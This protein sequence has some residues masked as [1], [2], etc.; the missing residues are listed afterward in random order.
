MV[1][2]IHGEVG[3]AVGR[4]W[5]KQVAILSMACI[6]TSLKEV[7]MEIILICI[8]MV[9]IA[10]SALRWG[11]DSRDAVDSQEWVRRRVWRAFH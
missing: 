9:V 2:E 5:Q 4:L 7:I 6:A 3:Q 11:F 8:V 1:R 10:L